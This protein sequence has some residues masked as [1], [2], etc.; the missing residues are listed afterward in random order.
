MTNLL[1]LKGQRLKSGSGGYDYDAIDDKR[2]GMVCVF[3]Q[4]ATA[5]ILLGGDLSRVPGVGSAC[6]LSRVML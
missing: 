3:G 1:S 4:G 5:S 2:N 6:T